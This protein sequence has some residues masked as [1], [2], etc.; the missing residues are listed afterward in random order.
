M[1][2]DQPFFIL[3]NPRSGTSLFRLMLNSHPILCIPP[4]CGFAQWWFD[5]Y[6]GWKKEDSTDPLKVDQFLTDLAGSKKIEG[7]RID[8]PKLKK[9]I[10]E[11]SPQNYAEL[12]GIV[13]V[14]YGKQ[15]GKNHIKWGD[16]NNYY[17]NYL[18]LI[19]KIYPKAKFIH[20]IR[21]GR[22]VACSYLDLQKLETNSRYKPVL[23][24][25]IEDIAR[26]WKKNITQ[27]ERH[28]SLLAKED[29][30]EIRY[31]DLIS[32]PEP[33]L[34]KV[35]AFL[36]VKYSS[37]LLTFYRSQYF[38]EPIETLDWKKKTMGEIDK[39]NTQKYRKIFSSSEI[40]R[41]NNICGNILLRYGY[42]I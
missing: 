25:N 40:G 14:F 42:E 3:G 2:L 5:R 7:W 37:D 13:Y 11:N 9:I 24:S 18:P 32:K 21:D 26:D 16:K 22:D 8:Y 12:C 28:F 34:K 41:F 39:K 38:D 23:A 30:L 31:E 36:G 33:T 35:M 6:G 27:I 17:I 20:L 29:Y 10:L 1:N 4:E 19:N 15:Q